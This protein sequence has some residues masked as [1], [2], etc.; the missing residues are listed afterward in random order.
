MSA[1]PLLAL[2]LAVG[3]A[4]ASGGRSNYRH[5]WD[6]REDFR[7]RQWSD[8]RLDKRVE[9]LPARPGVWYREEASDKRYDDDVHE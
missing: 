6:P 4:A 1:K 3:V 7:S 9:V 2:A 8:N 5:R